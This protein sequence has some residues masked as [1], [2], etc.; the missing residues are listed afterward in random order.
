MENFLKLFERN[1]E[2]QD[3]ERL[4]TN[5]SFIQQILVLL[6]E[7][8][9][10]TASYEEANLIFKI[11][12]DMQF[13]LAKAVFKNKIVVTPQ[14]RKFISD[15]DRIDDEALKNYLYSKIKSDEYKL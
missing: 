6:L 1:L 12:E 8:I 9:K 14:L 13:V 15:F 2:Y 5:L 4:I 7:Q 3:K 11:L 10:L